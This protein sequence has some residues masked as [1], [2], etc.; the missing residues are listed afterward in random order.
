[1]APFIDQVQLP[2]RCSFR[3]PPG[4]C[5]TAV[6]IFDL[7]PQRVGIALSGLSHLL[8]RFSIRLMLPTSD[9]YEA[10][11]SLGHEAESAGN[12]AEPGA[13]TGSP[14]EKPEIACGQGDT[15]LC[16]GMDDLVETLPPELQH[17][18]ELE[19]TT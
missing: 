8:A 3:V 15:E 7:S 2:P 16:D 6:P 18:A 4:F 14:T 1:M 11:N 19:E 10:A 12:V 5:L 9:K 13:D 17:L